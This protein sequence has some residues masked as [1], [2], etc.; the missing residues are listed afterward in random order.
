MNQTEN[1]TATARLN[2]RKIVEHLGG[3][4]ATRRML[5][6]GGVDISI[7]AIDKWRR[8][9]SIPGDKIAV[10]AAAAKRKRRAFNL[11]DFIETEGTN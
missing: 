2:A 3:L 11:Y 5:R 9:G 8:R 10:L 7:D 1:Q 6:E 4:A